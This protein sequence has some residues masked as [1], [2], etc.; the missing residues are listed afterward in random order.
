[1]TGH[2]MRA[3]PGV[4]QQLIEQYNIIEYFSRLP[5]GQLHQRTSAPH[6][7]LENLLYSRADFANYSTR[8]ITT[9]KAQYGVYQAAKTAT[10]CLFA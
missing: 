4:E 6:F 10:C 8:F 1:M 5:L 9:E 3:V 2:S 7:T